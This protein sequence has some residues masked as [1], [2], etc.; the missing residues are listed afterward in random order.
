MNFPK[1]PYLPFDEPIPAPPS[2]KGELCFT[3][4]A[5]WKPYLVGLIKTLLVDRTWQTDAYRSTGEA[6]LLLEAILT[7]DFCTIEQPGIEM[8]DC[9]CGCLR[10]ADGILQTF[11]CGVWTDVPG[12]NLNN[13]VQ[14]G[15]GNP[16]NTGGPLADGGCKEY[17][18]SIIGTLPTVLPIPLNAGDS[19][20]ITSWRGQ[21]SDGSG[22]LFAQPYF[23]ADGQEYLL[24]TCS[25]LTFTDGGDPLPSANHM[26]VVA[27]V[28]GNWLAPMGSA[29][30]VPPGVSNAQMFFQANDATLGDNLGGVSI[31]VKV[32]RPAQAPIAIAYSTG[33]GPASAA[34]GAVITLTS[35]LNGPANAQAIAISFSE[36][37][38]LSVV[39]GT[40]FVPHLA[41]GDW[42]EY[43]DCASVSHGSG[44]PSSGTVLTD[45]P[46]PKQ[47]NELQIAGLLSAIFQVQI[48]I[49]SAP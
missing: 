13:I 39:G 19:I 26:S 23:C 6:S 24:G 44:A 18:L 42:W 7:A 16:E 29:R 36:C 3:L 49:D 15:S 21:W 14:Q 40:G 45:F 1:Y 5:K 37:V 28:D 34:V 32:C 2:D 43:T 30:Y 20:E 17:D 35:A 11:S 41:A 25:G 33:S 46:S 22:A 8:G 31:H 48:R 27:G 9:M 10:V 38:T 4:D 47:A 12:G